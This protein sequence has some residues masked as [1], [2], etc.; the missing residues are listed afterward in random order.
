MEDGKTTKKTQTNKQKADSW[1]D[2]F[3]DE[4]NFVYKNPPQKI[5]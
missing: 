5:E 1:V 3:L 4:T 2:F